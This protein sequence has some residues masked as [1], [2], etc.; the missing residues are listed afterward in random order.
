MGSNRQLAALIKNNPLNL[1]IHL[2]IKQIQNS[3]IK[4]PLYLKDSKDKGLHIWRSGQDSNPRP[5]RDRP[6]ALIKNNL[7]NLIMHNVR[8][9][10]SNFRHKK[11]LLS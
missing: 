6:A 8:K 3:D 2:V 9:L 1:I 4:K 5:W 11:T 7:L 10:N